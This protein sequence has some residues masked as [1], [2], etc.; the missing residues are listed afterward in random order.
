M[1]KKPEACQHEGH[2]ALRREFGEEIC[3]CCTA[4]PRERRVQRRL[5]AHMWAA[6]I[7]NVAACALNMGTLIARVLGLI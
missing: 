2:C 5:K 1:G 7:A 4:S 3:K 6:L